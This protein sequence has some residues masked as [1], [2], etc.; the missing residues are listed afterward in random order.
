[1][2]LLANLLDITILQRFHAELF[3][4]NFLTRSGDIELNPG[5]KS[6]RGIGESVL[7]YVAKI[8]TQREKI[9]GVGKGLGIPPNEINMYLDLSDREGAY[10]MLKYWKEKSPAEKQLEYLTNALSGA[11]CRDIAGSNDDG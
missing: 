7:P 11:D 1:M 6:Y 4:S 10:Q 2:A 9:Q 5:P 8:I 3:L